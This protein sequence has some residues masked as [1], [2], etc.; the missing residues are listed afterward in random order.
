[1]VFNEDDS[2]QLLAPLPAVVLVS[3]HEG[4]R[5]ESLWL[6]QHPAFRSMMERLNS[7]SVWT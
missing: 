3:H 5:E 6:L 7:I 4:A 1:M 2:W